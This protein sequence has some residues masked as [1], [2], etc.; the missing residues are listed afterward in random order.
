MLGGVH[1]EELAVEVAPEDLSGYL[2]RDAEVWTAFLAGRP[3]FVRK[4]VWLP[5]DRP[6][7]VVIQIW[8]RT[9]EDWKAIT[10]EQVAEVDARM[11]PYRREPSGQEYRVLAVAP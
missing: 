4:E 5:V 2:A 9:R 1:V 10:P 11:G 7:V 3:G 8:W 6:G